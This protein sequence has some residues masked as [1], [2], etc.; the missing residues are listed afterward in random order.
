[1]KSYMFQIRHK[2]SQ[3][4]QTTTPR[5]ILKHTSTKTQSIINTHAIK[6]DEKTLT[7]KT[8]FIKQHQQDQS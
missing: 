8:N 1:M 5:P 6:N 2:L 4:N 3:S 7:T